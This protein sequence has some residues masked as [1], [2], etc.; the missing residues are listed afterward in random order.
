[1]LM[2]DLCQNK[3]KYKR[4]NFKIYAITILILNFEKKVLV[5]LNFMIY[6]STAVDHITWLHVN[7]DLDDWTMQK[8]QG[9]NIYFISDNYVTSV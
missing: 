9:I 3:L 8:R 6:E 2:P 4:C 7:R 5:L 1:M